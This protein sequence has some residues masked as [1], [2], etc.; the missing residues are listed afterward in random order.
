MRL[1]MKL[2]HRLEMVRQVGLAVVSLPPPLQAECWKVFELEDLVFED[3]HC[4]PV[5]ELHQVFPDQTPR[6]CFHPE[7]EA[8][9]LK[10]LV[11]AS[12][13]EAYSPIWCQISLFDQYHPALSLLV[14]SKLL[15]F[16]L[17]DPRQ[18]RM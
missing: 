17:P 9:Q 6:I 11:W 5:R 13:L 14:L 18:K 12:S 15:S 3:N 2:L 7:S 10:E 4:L 8:L 16:R 1:V